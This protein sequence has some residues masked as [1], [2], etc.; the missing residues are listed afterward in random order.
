MTPAARYIGSVYESCVDRRLNLAQI[1]D[2][3][4]THGIRRLASQ[5][6]HELDNVYCFAGY[7]A[8]HPAPAV[9]TL[10]QIDALS[11]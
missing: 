5:V 1:K 7:S 8:S 3:L 2:Y 10:K 11:G 9:L 4:A 6:V